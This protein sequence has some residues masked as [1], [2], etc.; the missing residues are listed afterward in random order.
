MGH[1][2]DYKAKDYKEIERWMSGHMIISEFWL[3]NSHIYMH[4]H[5]HWSSKKETHQIKIYIFKCNLIKKLWK[6]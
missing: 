5:V 1:I 6:E 4:S 3:V 2:C